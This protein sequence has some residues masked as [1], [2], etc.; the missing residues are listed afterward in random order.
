MAQPFMSSYPQSISLLYPEGIDCNRS[1][2]L[3]KYTVKLLY[4]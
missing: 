2:L 4:G 1:E 3:G